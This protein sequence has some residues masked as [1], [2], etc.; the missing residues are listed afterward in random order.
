LYVSSP[1]SAPPLPPANKTQSIY[2]FTVL[3]YIIIRNLVQH[4]A[5]A[6]RLQFSYFT[7]LCYWGL[8]FYFLV[9]ALHTLTYAISGAT[10]LLNRFWRPFQALHYLFYSSITTFP[11]LVTIVYWA[12]LYSKFDSIYHIWSNT[13]EHGL[14]S[15][16]ALFEILMTRINPPPW[17]HLLWLIVILAAYLGLAYLT[18]ATKHVYVYNF[19]NPAPKVLNAEGHNVGGV[20]GLVAAY[21]VGIAVGICVLFCVVKGL[22]WVRKWVTETKCGMMGKF[23]AGREIGQVEVE[24]ENQRVWEK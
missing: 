12:V 9:A 17:V 3:L 16:F 5:S 1:L 6:A 20:G 18:H 21:V 8:A 2:C 4:S 19:L 22:V 11:L 10:P 23:Y 15:L 24:L 13:S 7:V 14:N